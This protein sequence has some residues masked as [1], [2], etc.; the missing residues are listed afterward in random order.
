MSIFKLFA[1]MQIKFKLIA[2]F[3]FVTIL[4]TVVAGIYQYANQS[5]IK[6]YDFA[7]ENP[8]GGAFRLY[9][10]RLQIGQ[11]LADGFQFG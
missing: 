7:I 4:F 1:S 6:G 5:I 10:A 2:A 3:F 8:I 11:S 9:D